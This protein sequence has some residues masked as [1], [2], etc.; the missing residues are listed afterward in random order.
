M[1]TGRDGDDVT[2]AN[3][4]GKHRKVGQLRKS[5]AQEGLLRL[6]LL[7]TKA[8]PLSNSPV[9]PTSNAL[10]EPPKHTLVSSH[11]SSFVHHDLLSSVFGSS[12]KV[13]DV[14]G[15]VVLLEL[16]SEFDESLLV[17]GEGEGRAEEDDDSLTLGFVLSVFE[18]ELEVGL[19]ACERERG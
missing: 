19:K 7:K 2:E 16:L 18:G 4:G 15:D 17:C 3:E 8:R 13:N 11:S 5:E 9:I 1:R 6:S 14:Y 10:H 12:S